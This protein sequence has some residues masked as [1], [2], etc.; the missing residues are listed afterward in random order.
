MSGIHHVTSGTFIINKTLIDNMP[1]KLSSKS[2]ESIKTVINWIPASDD[3]KLRYA[4]E[5]GYQCDRLFIANSMCGTPSK[6]GNISL[7]ETN[8]IPESDGSSNIFIAD[9]TLLSALRIHDVDE[10]ISLAASNLKANH[11]PWLIS[12]RSV[13]V[14]SD[15]L[16]LCNIGRKN[17]A[18]I[19]KQ[20]VKPSYLYNFNIRFIYFFISYE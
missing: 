7:S 12:C 10:N 3:E 17:R 4:K 14:H 6:A 16:S 1:P 15:I 18:H 8:Q 2:N 9:E 13:F 19:L 11:W 20:L 5:S